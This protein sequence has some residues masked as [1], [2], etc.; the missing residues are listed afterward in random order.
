[1]ATSILMETIV[2]GAGACGLT[3]GLALLKHLPPATHSS[4]MIS[5]HILKW[6]WSPLVAPEPHMIHRQIS[7]QAPPWV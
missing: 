2:L 3:I 6:C 1:M 4:G 7:S 5:N